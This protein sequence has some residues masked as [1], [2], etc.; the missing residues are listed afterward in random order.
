M[1]SIR[2]AAD[3]RAIAAAVA[4]LLLALAVAAAVRRAPPRFARLTPFAVVR[5]AAGRPLW[6]LRLAPAAH[7]IAA[8][9]VGGAPPPAGH[10]YQLWLALPQGPR[11]LGLLPATGRKVVPETPAAV[12]RLQ[13][14]GALIVTLEAARGSRRPRPSGPVAFRARFGGGR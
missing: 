6:A 5:D 9:R 13:G 3:R 10:A 14:A 7:E 4:V 11:S 1:R 12:A 2:A 8:D